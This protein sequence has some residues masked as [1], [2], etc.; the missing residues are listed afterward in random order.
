MKIGAEDK[1]KV[2]SAIVQFLSSSSAC[3]RN[4]VM[5]GA[6]LCYGF[7]KK[8]ISNAHSAS[9]TLNCIRSYIGTA[10]TD[11]VSQGDV[12]ID[13]NKRYSLAKEEL[14]IV[15]EAECRFEILRL[16]KGKSV[17]KAD[18]YLLLQK[19][20]GTDKTASKE[21]DHSLRQIAGQIIA[22]EKNKGNI[23][24]KDGLLSLPEKK[25]TVKYTANPLPEEEF[26]PL[27]L[28]RIN[29][30]G[31]DFFEKF[32]A[33]MLEKYYLI[34]GR[35]VLSCDIIGGCDDGGVDIIMETEEDLG[36]V[37]KII[38]QVK[39]RKNIQVT[40]KEI[41]EFYG[42]MNVQRGTRGIFVTTAAFH[43]SADKL[44]FSLPNC[45]GINGEKLFSLVKQTVY[46]I[47]KTKSGFTFDN[48]IFVK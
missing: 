13:K 32:V 30:L 11:L 10:L 41:R 9:G 15:K 23:Q 38:I 3:T 46:G 5:N 27:F 44:L 48:A 14:V 16:L 24:E 25:S 43:P 39:N 12:V 26:V 22:E 1:K 18:L 40:E 21:D 8:E 19:K 20:F 37:D 2:I 34:N 29:D 35:D 33:N 36:F 31:G 17:K 28:S 4:E 6:L 45:V 7:S 42:V 47:H